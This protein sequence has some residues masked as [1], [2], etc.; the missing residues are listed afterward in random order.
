MKL[1]NASELQEIRGRTSN[2][3]C[4]NIAQL[5]TFINNSISK[6]NCKIYSTDQMKSLEI[7]QKLATLESTHKMLSPELDLVNFVTENLL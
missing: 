4:T 2:L 5:L 3:Y 1:L 7:A 6:I